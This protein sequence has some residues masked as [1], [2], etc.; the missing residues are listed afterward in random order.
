MLGG[1][2][3]GGRSAT[4]AAARCWTVVRQ[5]RLEGA[6]M[7]A[8]GRGYI[9]TLVSDMRGPMV[10]RK[11]A[12]WAGAVALARVLLDQVEDGAWHRGERVSVQ[13]AQAEA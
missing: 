4:L 12:T 7:V 11:A 8:I 5:R 6:I 3:F 10:T 13:V 9:A 1:S 2:R